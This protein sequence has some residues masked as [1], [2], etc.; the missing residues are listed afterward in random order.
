MVEPISLDPVDSLTITTL[1]DNVSDLLLVDEGP[2]K[3][4]PLDLS[5]YPRTTARVLEG[6]E[7]GDPLRAEHG[8]SCLVAITKAERT[9]RTA[10]SR[11]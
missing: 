4:A 7:T 1:V 3:R 2:A 11:T 10:W 9:I 8:F 5:A 6:G